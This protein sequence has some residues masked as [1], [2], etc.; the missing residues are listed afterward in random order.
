MPS[1]TK[2][3]L[4]Q[5]CC[6]DIENPAVKM[7]LTAFNE[8]VTELAGKCNVKSISTS[9]EEDLKHALLK[10]ENI[11]VVQDSIQKNILELE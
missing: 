9:S 2:Q 7:N 6:K 5:L 11:H 4:T 8:I 10:L 3:H 1:H